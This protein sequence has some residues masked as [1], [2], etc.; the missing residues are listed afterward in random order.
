METKNGATTIGKVMKLPKLQ[1]LDRYIIRKF[2]G[3]FFF[4]ITLIVAIAVIFD[5]S[6]KLD[7]FIDNS[8]PIKAVIFG[9]YANF[10]PYFA[11][12]F[13]PL[14]TFISVIYFTSRLAYNT[15]IIA[16]L[17]SGISFKR[18]LWPYFVSAFVVMTF[19]FVLNNYLIPHA[20]ARKLA[21]EEVY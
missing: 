13:S 21:F 19:A 5:L 7:D 2:L 20:N 14:F 9:Y 8:A 11:V 17:S 10:A 3:T 18:M 1:I 15:E 12:Q 6:E 4:T 16:I